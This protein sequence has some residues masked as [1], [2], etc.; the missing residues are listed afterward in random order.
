MSTKKITRLK[1]TCNKCGWHW[2]SRKAMSPAVCPECCNPRWNR[3]KKGEE[4][5]E[6]EEVK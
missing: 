6:T 2:T 4:K 3:E 1:C 5:K